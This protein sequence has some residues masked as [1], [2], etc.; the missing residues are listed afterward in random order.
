MKILSVHARY[1]LPGGEDEVFA[2]ERDLLRQ[3]GNEVLEH[4]EDNASIAGQGKL[5]LAARTIWSRGDYERIRATIRQHGI[6]L[7]A[8]HNFFPLISPAVFHA[9]RAEGAAVVQTLHNYR[10]ICPKATLM[11]DG[12]LCDD[13]VGRT[14]PLPAIEHSCYRG[15]RVLTGVLATMLAVHHGMGTWQKTVTRYIALTDYMRDWFVAGGLPAE[16]VVVK[17]NF[18]PD[19]GVGSGDGRQFVFVGRLTVEKGVSVLLQAWRQARPDST[20]KIIGSGPDEVALRAE[21]GGLPNVVFLGHQPRERVVEE[22]KRATAV[23]VPSIWPEPFGL[24]IIEALAAGTPVLATDHAGMASLVQ[25]GRG[26]FVFPRGDSGALGRL[27]QGQGALEALRP[28][29]R[30]VYEERFTPERNYRELLDIYEQAR[31]AVR[32]PA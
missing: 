6:E 15:S 25:P 8:V 27:L 3:H 28:S 14:F 12:A 17:P 30:A 16:R 10:L 26:G 23:V 2:A 31:Q 32:S 11:R 18:V 7:V 29:A 20:L 24:T 22:M 5:G 19:Y 21:A 4:V 13:C 9:A 1:A